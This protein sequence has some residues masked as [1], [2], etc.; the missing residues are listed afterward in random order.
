MFHDGCI[1]SVCAGYDVTHLNNDK[2]CHHVTE[3]DCLSFLSVQL[4]SCEQQ[5]L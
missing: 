5:G 4:Q 3:L 2:Q 1:I